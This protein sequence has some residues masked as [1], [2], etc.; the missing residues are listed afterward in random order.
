MFRRSAAAMLAVAAISACTHDWDEFDPRL[1]SAGGGGSGGAAGP[2]PTTTTS[3]N[4]TVSSTSMSSMTQTTSTMSSTSVSSAGGGGEG[5]G[6][7]EYGAA[8]ADC[9]NPGAP[10]PDACALEVGNGRM[11]VDSEWN[12]MTD[13]TPRHSYLRFD[14]DG[15]IAGKTVDSVAVRLHVPNIAGAESTQ[16]GDMWEVEPF[17]RPSL[18]GS[19]PMNVGA[20]PI[21]PN[22][23]AVS[24]DQDVFFPLP[25]DSVA[26]DGSV[27]LGILP[28]STNGVDYFNA[29]GAEPPALVISYH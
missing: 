20:A 14:L 17:D 25:T 2:G 15:A 18:F 1:G 8:V 29:L 12:A 10:D 3:G 19:V 11:T 28:L 22:L 9:V 6:Q 24:L 4:M 21:S 23:G 16:T 26:A 5:P 27:F 7:V 13:P